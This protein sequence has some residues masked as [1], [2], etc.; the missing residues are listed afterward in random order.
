MGRK[1]LPFKKRYKNQGVSQASFL[2]ACRA[3][4]FDALNA[5]LEER[6]R[7]RQAEVPGAQIKSQAWR[8]SEPLI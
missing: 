5:A 2:M 4:S 7:A 8:L 6:C 1:F 3:A